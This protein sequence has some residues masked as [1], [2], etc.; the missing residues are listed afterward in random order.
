MCISAFNHWIISGSDFKEEAWNDAASMHF[1]A[2]NMTCVQCHRWTNV[3]PGAVIKQFSLILL[4]IRKCFGE[5]KLAHTSPPLLF[6]TPLR[7]IPE[8]ARLFSLYSG[9]SVSSPWWKGH[10]QAGNKEK[11]FLKGVCVCRWEGKPSFSFCY[12]FYFCLEKYAFFP[13][14]DFI[15]INGLYWP[16]SP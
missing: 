1:Q 14:F 5:K 3:N 8:L 2:W 9:E 7:P 16:H 6:L 10:F 12:D 15:F 13:P 4:H 11:F